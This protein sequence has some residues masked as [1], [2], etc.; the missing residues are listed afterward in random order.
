MNIII[1]GKSYSSS[2]QHDEVTLEIKA[3]DQDAYW[4]YDDGNGNPIYDKDTGV[5]LRDPVTGQPTS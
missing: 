2:A 3:V 4:E 5:Q 1:F